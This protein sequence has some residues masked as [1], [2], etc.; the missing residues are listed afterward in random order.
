MESW[1]LLSRLVPPPTLLPARQG[2]LGCGNY[3][4]AL[5]P[6]ILLSRLVPPPMLLV[7]QA[8]NY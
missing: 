8:E 7:L 4:Y 3:D 1:I 2:E 6:W 5:V